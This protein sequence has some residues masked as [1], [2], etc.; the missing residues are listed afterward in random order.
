MNWDAVGAIAEIGGAF[1]V[2]V[3]LFYLAL[4]LRQA[5]QNIRISVARSQVDS[6]IAWLGQLITDPSAYH[7]YREGL[8]A[9]D[10]LSVEDRGRFDLLLHQMFVDANTQF[11]QLTS[12]AMEEEHWRTTNEALLLV[13]R[14]VGGKRSWDRQKRLLGDDF[15]AR[16]EETLLT[17]QK[18]D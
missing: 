4:Q 16:V 12:G 6:Q 18:T 5:N 8:K 7:L 10:A 2:I 11:R 3:T 15:V 9:S 1:A 13:L 17:S 14:T